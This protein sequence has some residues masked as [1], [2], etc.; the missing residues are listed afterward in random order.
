MPSAS[1]IVRNPA[2]LV[3]GASVLSG[4][5]GYVVTTIVAARLGPAGYAGFAVFWSSLYL[6]VGA[7]GG[8]QQEATRAST[9]AELTGGMGGA[10]LGAFGAIAAAA[11]F[12]ILLG[13][14]PAWSGPV[15]TESGFALA[16]PLA[17][18]A[19]SYVLVA[20]VCGGLYGIRRWGWL[21]VLIAGDGILRLIGV[22]AVL[23]F[24]G[25]VVPLAW[26][27]ALP[28][29]VTLALVVPFLARDLRRALRSDVGFGRLARNV[30]RTVV[31]A[32]AMATLISGFPLLVSVT[33]PE[34]PAAVLGTLILAFTLARA[35]IVV[36]L[37]ALQS[38]LIVK[39][40]EPEWPRVRRLL[41]LGATVLIA[42]IVLGAAAAAFGVPLLELLFGTQAQ[43]AS[44]GLFWIVGS[45]GLV[46]ALC[47]TGPALL[48]ESRLGL[49]AVG[50]AVS[51]L[52]A[53]TVLVL[54]FDL[55]AR[56]ALAL[57]VGPVLGLAVHGLGLAVA[58]RTDDRRRR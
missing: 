48:A 32:A 47:I 17:V 31:A 58:W 30:L 13:T 11:L 52:G 41:Q 40:A 4:A 27:V 9:S 20:T 16:A 1:A 24:G 7:F 23:L 33:S 12:A 15:F 28:F 57:I 29:P 37:M 8:V 26:A 51:A 46:A 21:A 34:A 3:L 35:P 5:A 55:T 18:G 22:G 50:W 36:P 54:P 38:Y 14:A 2:V 19:A 44:A 56:L 6:V 25:S 42:G 53:V 49:Y 10:R 45:A 39:F 43:V